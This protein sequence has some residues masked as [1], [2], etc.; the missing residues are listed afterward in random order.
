MPGDFIITDGFSDTKKGA[1]QAAPNFSISN[2][3][4]LN[5]SGLQTGCTYI[6]LSGSAVHL[7]L[8]RLNIGFPHLVGTSM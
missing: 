8:Y 3:S 6:H 7:N 5:C 2:L 1:A 4:S